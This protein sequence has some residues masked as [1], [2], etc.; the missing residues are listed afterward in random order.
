MVAVIFFVA[1]F[2]LRTPH[3]K[4][5]RGQMSIAPLLLLEAASQE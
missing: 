3:F 4:S 2:I 1:Y 5:E